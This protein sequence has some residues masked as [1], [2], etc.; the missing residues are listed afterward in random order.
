MAAPQAGGPGH[1]CN[2]AIANALRHG[3][4]RATGRFQVSAMLFAVGII[5]AW[6]RE[7]ATPVRFIVTGNETPNEWATANCQRPARK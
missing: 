2:A 1:P 3:K 7:S 4:P 6:S 5:A